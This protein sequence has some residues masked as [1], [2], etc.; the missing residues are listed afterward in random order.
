MARQTNQGDRS[1]PAPDPI[2]AKAQRLGAD[3]DL[4]ESDRRRAMTCLGR[5]IEV[6][7]SNCQGDPPAISRTLEEFPVSL[8][9]EAALSIGFE[10]ALA[11]VEQEDLRNLVRLME[12]TEYLFA[13]DVPLYTI[14][15]LASYTQAFVQF[16]QQHREHLIR[17]G[18]PPKCFRECPW[19]Y[20]RLGRL[21]DTRTTSAPYPYNELFTVSREGS[22]PPYRWIRMVQP[23]LPN[24]MV[25]HYGGEEKRREYCE[26]ED[27][28]LLDGLPPDDAVRVEQYR[29]KIFDTRL[30]ILQQLAEAADRDSAVELWN[31]CLAVLKSA[32][33]SE[34]IAFLLRMD[35]YYLGT[36]ARTAAEADPDPKATPG[37]LSNLFGVIGHYV[38]EL[39]HRF[40]HNVRQGIP[41]EL[42]EL[43]GAA[44]GRLPWRYLGVLG[45]HDRGRFDAAIGSWLS[46]ALTERSFWLEYR[47]RLEEAL[48]REFRVIV[49]IEVEPTHV[50]AIRGL[51]QDYADHLQA[52][53]ERGELLVAPPD[54]SIFRRDG[55]SWTIAFGGKTITKKLTLGLHHIHYLLGNPSRSFTAMELRASFVRW[56]RDPKQSE[57]SLVV[58]AG[59]GEEME[60]GPDAVQLEVNDLGEEMDARAISECKARIQELEAG[61]LQA[62]QIGDEAKANECQRE[63]DNIRDYLKKARD[64]RG[65]INRMKDR[66]KIANDSVRNA[67]ER[68]LADLQTAHPSL[69][70][71]LRQFMETRVNYCYSPVPA[72]D[73]DL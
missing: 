24:L 40:H 27:A 25:R 67:M 59:A 46:G 7:A 49:S 70:E 5:L 48:S 12:A 73:W 21:Y 1:S 34:E 51:L 56:R 60:D 29:P 13:T 38:A 72:V 11:L 62:R 31:S 39:Q 3:Y 18:L 63:V 66:T 20:V 37:G 23:A 43:V 53:R 15:G 54:K 44:E 17:T 2:E 28:D 10:Q 41:E 33:N 47:S 35:R 45:H 58:V 26:Y 4:S 8:M 19:L 65:R 16:Q 42:Y 22:T 64:P 6:F 61:L 71:H 57:A 52:K 14:A 30:K 36:D 9:E 55:N 50:D 69:Y 32:F 68:A